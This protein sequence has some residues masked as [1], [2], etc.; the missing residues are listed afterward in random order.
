M[1]RCVGAARLLY[2]VLMLALVVA[3]LVVLSASWHS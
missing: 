3:A 1:E 2:L